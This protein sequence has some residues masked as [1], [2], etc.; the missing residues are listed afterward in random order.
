MRNPIMKQEN[1]RIRFNHNNN[2][3]FKENKV[4]FL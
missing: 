2:I 3:I 1:G 4:I